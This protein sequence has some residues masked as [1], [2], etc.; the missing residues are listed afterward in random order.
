MIALARPINGRNRIVDHFGK[1]IIS[2]PRETPLAPP[3]KTNGRR[4]DATYDAARTT[5]GFKNYWAN[6]DA[7][8][9]DSA[10][11]RPVREKMVQRARYETANNGY[12]DGMIQTHAF[13]YLVGVGPTLRM[14]AK[15]ATFNQVVETLFWNWMKAIQFTR[16]LRCMAH[17]KVQDGEGL[18][19]AGTNPKVRHRVKLDIRLIET[20]QCQTP[21]L[22][23][24]EKG[25]IDG[26]TFD[27]WG[28]PETYQILTAHP[29]SNNQWTYDPKP[30]N[31]P[32]ANVMHWFTMRRPGQH[33]GVPEFASTL[34]V[35]AS[36]R[37]FREATVRAAEV[38]AAHALML[39]TDQVPDQ[40]EPVTPLTTLDY[41]N[42]M[43][44]A[45]PR[46]YKVSQIDGKHPNALYSEFL[47]AQLSETGRPKCMPFNLVACDSSTYSFASGK[48]DHL[49]Y[50]GGIDVEREDCNDQ[51]LDPLFALWW[52][53]AVLV[54]GFNA[55]PSTPPPHGWNWPKHPVADIGGEANARDTNLKNGSTGLEK[56]YA[57]AGMDYEDEVQ[58]QAESYGIPV[59]DMRQIHL[60]T[61]YPAAAEVLDP[62]VVPAI[63][64]P[65]EASNAPA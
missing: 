6:A 25:K 43:M 11:S 28:N 48:L 13:T 27:E 17:A 3:A 51:V 47:R 49:S 41:E 24:G 10:N 1:A 32:A 58:K 50:F 36:S 29:G 63:K 12:V 61:I 54:Y 64:Q 55:D 31:I 19:V 20:E 23:F 59:E 33:R 45:L 30:E 22:I 9:A 60:R 62:P 40:F 4:L 16:K 56:V 35:G 52:A 46:G 14:Q 18:A 26:I 15:D 5:D 57:D 21:Y 38:A 65:Q 34:N 8:D 42:G 37:R 39:E 44:T 7:L 2:P 53:E